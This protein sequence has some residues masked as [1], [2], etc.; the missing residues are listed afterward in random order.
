MAEHDIPD[1]I[2]IA[3]K[4]G[5]PT[6]FIGHL[7]DDRQFVAL[8]L[9]GPD[10]W[11]PV[12][13]FFA[14]EGDYVESERGTP[15]PGDGDEPPEEAR[16]AFDRMLRQLE[17]YRKDAVTVSQFETEIGHRRFGLIPDHEAGTLRFEPAGMVFSAPWEG[18]YRT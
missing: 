2:R 18:D 13:L 11:M 7:P 8:L 17:P 6:E 3:R 14:A 12:V 1:T 9:P 4:K 10:G 16:E 5:G 15:V